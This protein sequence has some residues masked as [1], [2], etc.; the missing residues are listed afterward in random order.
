MTFRPPVTSLQ[1]DR[2]FLL[3]SC[4]PTKHRTVLRQR[5]RLASRPLRTLLR[6]PDR[7]VICE[8]GDATGR[9]LMAGRKSPGH[10]LWIVRRPEDMRAPPICPRPAILA[11]VRIPLGS[12][13]L[14]RRPL[15]GR[16]DRRPACA[17]RSPAT[18]STLGRTTMAYGVRGTPPG[19]DHKCIRARCVARTPC[20]SFSLLHR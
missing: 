12:R 6:P 8:R 18:Q 9:P 15:M 1:R 4:E 11:L 13:T 5:P 7:N 2:E 3:A 20:D 16:G 14:F 10:G 19:I 17:P